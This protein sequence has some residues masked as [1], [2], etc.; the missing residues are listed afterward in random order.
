[1]NIKNRII[2]SNTLSI[3]KYVD[4][5]KYLAIA[6][7]LCILCNTNIPS[8]KNSTYYNNSIDFLT[9]IARNNSIYF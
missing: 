8:Y 3:I 2:N 6:S 9:N 1:M 7:T 4:G 5:F